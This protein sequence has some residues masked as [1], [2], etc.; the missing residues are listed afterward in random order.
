MRPRQK[1]PNPTIYCQAL[2]PFLCLCLCVSKSLRKWTQTDTKVTFHPPPPPPPTTTRKLFLVSNERYGKNKTF[3]LRWY[4][5]D[6]APIK[7]YRPFC[8][9]WLFLRRQRFSFCDLFQLSLLEK[10]HINV[11][12]GRPT[13]FQTFTIRPVIDEIY[14]F[15]GPNFNLK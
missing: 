3:L 15:S 10:L 11:K 6:F 4:G 5:I 14:K 13:K 2:C 1:K 7:R 8:F 9:L 12:K